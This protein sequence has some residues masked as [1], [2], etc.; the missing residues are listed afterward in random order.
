[1]ND[2]FSVYLIY[3]AVFMQLIGLTFAAIIDPYINKKHRTV[4]L[5][6]CFLTLVLIIQNY[7]ECSFG[8]VKSEYF[9]RLI[10][11]ILGYVIRPVIIVMWLY[12]IRKK[13][14]LIMAWILIAINAL[15]HLTALFTDVCFTISPDNSFQRGPLGYTCHVISGILLLYLFWLSS[16]MY[17]DSVN[18]KI[19]SKGINTSNNSLSAAG[20]NQ[21]KKELMKYGYGLAGL[22][23]TW[24]VI[25]I[26]LSV[27][28]DTKIYSDYEPIVFLTV[29]IVSSNLFYYIWL[30]LGFV[31]EYEENIRTKLQ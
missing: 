25:M 22:I 13:Q 24:C 17:I 19:E 30:H 1:M 8:L 29:A 11:S 10:V 26:I 12:L 20:S 7:L 14:R 9:Y 3:F 27:V 21:L 16:D 28:M 2:F 18:G 4:I 31:R 5:I 15:I 23:P 6:N